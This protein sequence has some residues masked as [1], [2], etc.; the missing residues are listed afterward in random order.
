MTVLA[1]VEQGEFGMAR[2]IAKV[3]E[4]PGTGGE[5]FMDENGESNS[6]RTPEPG[7]SEGNRDD[8]YQAVAGG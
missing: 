8:S 2:E 5:K 7:V 6:N 1:F 3:F 4:P